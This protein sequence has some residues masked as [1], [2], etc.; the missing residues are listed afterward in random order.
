MQSYKV[1]HFENHNPGKRFPDFRSVSPEEANTYRTAINHLTKPILHPALLDDVNALDDDFD[2]LD[3]WKKGQIV[4]ADDLLLSFD[5][6]GSVDEMH[7]K[8]LERCFGD[9]WYP[10]SDD[11]FVF[12]RSAEWAL[13]VDHDG[14]IYVYK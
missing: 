1:R 5:V 4:P 6:L 3:V 10:T 8:D 7:R 2:L 9:I 13:F 11:L 12:D 14:N